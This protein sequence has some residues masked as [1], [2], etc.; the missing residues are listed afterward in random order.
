MPETPS[1]HAR[2]RE[3]ATRLWKIS[4]EMVGLKLN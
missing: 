3:S 1:I 2:N 4:E